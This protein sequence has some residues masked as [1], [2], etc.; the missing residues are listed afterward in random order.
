MNIPHIVFAASILALVLLTPSAASAGYWKHVGWESCHD[1]CHTDGDCR[2]YC[3]VLL[4]NLCARNE[5]PT[6]NCEVDEFCRVLTES[7]LEQ[8]RCVPFGIL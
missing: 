2:K 8:Y 7:S 4:P 3:A 6:G 1:W 5:V